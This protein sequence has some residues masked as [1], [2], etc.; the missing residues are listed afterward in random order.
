[1]KVKADIGI[2]GMANSVHKSPQR[3]I[4]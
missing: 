2:S 3:L 4:H 1:M